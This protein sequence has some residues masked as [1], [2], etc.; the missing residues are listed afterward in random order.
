[1]P[2]VTASIPHQLT[3]AE[4][5]RRIQEGIAAARREHQS[6]LTSVQETWV[7]DTLNF[8]FT[9]MGQS[10]SGRLAVEEQVVF[11]SVAL[12]WFLQMLAGRIKPMIEQQGQRMLGR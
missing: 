2:D 7:E 9:A 8:S 6:I 11:V 10:V 12:P 5:K 4:A 1:M 3:P